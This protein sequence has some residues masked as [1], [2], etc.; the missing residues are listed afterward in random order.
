MTERPCDFTRDCIKVPI[1]QKCLNYCLERIL[2]ACTVE[3]KQLVLG[4]PNDLAMKIFSIYNKFDINSYK[5]LSGHLK[6]SERRF[7][8][9]AFRRLSQ[10]QLNYLNQPRE[11]RDEIIWQLKRL[12][13]DKDG[14]GSDTRLF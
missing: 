1:P 13:L 4:F 6:P 3:E 14:G 11:V 5:D 2:R 9:Y 10:Y 7:I 12:G 8:Y